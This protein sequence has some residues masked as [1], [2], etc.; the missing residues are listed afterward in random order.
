M[1]NV[2]SSAALLLVLS[3]GIAAQKQGGGNN[4][5]GREPW[6]GGKPNSGGKTGE[7][8][9]LDKPKDNKGGD[10]AKDKGGDKPKDKGGDK[11]K[12]KG[13]DKPKD[14]GG[15][16]PKENKGGDKPKDKK[17]GGKS[18]ENKGGDRPRNGDYNQPWGNGPKP[19]DKRPEW[20]DGRGAEWGRGGEYGWNHVGGKDGGWVGGRA[21]D[22]LTI[23]YRPDWNW[24]VPNYFEPLYYTQYIATPAW[25]V[26]VIPVITIEA[27]PPIVPEVTWLRNNSNNH[28]YNYRNRATFTSTI[29]EAPEGLVTVYQDK[30]GLEYTYGAITVFEVYIYTTTQSVDVIGESCF[31]DGPGNEGNGYG[32]GN[33]GN[34]GG[35]NGGDG[36]FTNSGNGGVGGNGGNIG[37]GGAFLPP[38][39]PPPPPAQPAQTWTPPSYKDKMKARRA[40]PVNIEH[41]RSPAWVEART[42]P[43]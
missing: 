43:V 14:K 36:V 10:K 6:V 31:G 8:K 7:N 22:Y 3:S 15:D 21:P 39:Q 40:S 27:P 30:D 4:G 16:K 19:G 28:T 42:T 2:L 33:G 1:R 29:T 11:P 17:N 38:G 13:S 26:P 23:E 12:D 25:P 9:G 35:N 37:D 41:R 20:N 5:G 24:N 18:K 34:N 32:Y